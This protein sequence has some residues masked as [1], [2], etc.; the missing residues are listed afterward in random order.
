M[1]DLR[2]RSGKDFPKSHGAYWELAPVWDAIAT[3]FTWKRIEP[4]TVR[5][6]RRL[7]FEARKAPA[8]ADPDGSEMRCGR[9]TRIA[10]RP[11]S[12]SGGSRRLP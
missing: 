2:V 8:P 5:E 6:A 3:A 10:R 9:R 4:L 1:V 11:R 7:G 12:L